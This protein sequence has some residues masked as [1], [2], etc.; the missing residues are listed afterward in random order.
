MSYNVGNKV[1][2]KSV[3]WYNENKDKEGIV[4]MGCGMFDFVKPMAEYLG[5]EANITTIVDDG[6][7]LIDLDGG[8]CFWIDEMFEGLVS[9]EKPI[10]STDLIKDIAELI[11]THNLGVSVSEN[12]G[13]LI[14]EPLKVEKEDEDLPIDTPCMVSDDAED[15][16]LRY[17]CGNNQ[18]FSDGLK[19]YNSEYKDGDEWL[20]IIEF[21]KF[22]PNDIESSLQYNIV[23]NNQ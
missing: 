3:E 10:I 17:Y 13:K 18:C 20:Y 5:K 21:S 11:K 12:D 7:Y 1:R 23:K 14:I 19:S 4:K 9:V 2:I 8:D 22:N 16:A 15:W 6:V